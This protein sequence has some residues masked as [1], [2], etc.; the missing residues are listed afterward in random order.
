MNKRVLFNKMALVMFSLVCFEFTSCSNDDER[1]NNA[2]NASNI[3]V[4]EN[5]GDPTWD[6]LAV[7]DHSNFLI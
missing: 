3:L 6:Y 7:D 4:Y 2:T 5:L 1:E